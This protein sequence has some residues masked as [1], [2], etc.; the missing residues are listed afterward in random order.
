MPSFFWGTGSL[1][2]VNPLW[3]K[4]EGSKV[5][6]S[7]HYWF[8][9]EQAKQRFCALL[10]LP[11]YL[12]VLLS[13]CFFPLRSFH[14]TML[15]STVLTEYFKHFFISTTLKIYSAE[16]TTLLVTYAHLSHTSV[17]NYFREETTTVTAKESIIKGM[18]KTE[19]RKTASNISVPFSRSVMSNSL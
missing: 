13:Y 2:R 6:R 15:T 1:A 7:L 12:T 16:E 9:R 3:G 5:G 17:W 18:V 11:R 8:L 19:Y 14:H 10:S 4:D